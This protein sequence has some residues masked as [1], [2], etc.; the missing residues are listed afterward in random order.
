MM[1]VANTALVRKSS[2]ARFD[3]VLHPLEESDTAAFTN[4][5]KGSAGRLLSFVGSAFIKY[6]KK[7]PSRKY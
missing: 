4:G 5:V 3:P 6:G 1:Q 2:V 7:W